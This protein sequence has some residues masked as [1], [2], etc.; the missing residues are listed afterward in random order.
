MTED[1]LLCCLE[2]F[3]ST[4][5]ELGMGLGL[6]LVRD[7]VRRHH[8]VLEVESAPGQGA[9]FTIRLP[10]PPHSQPAATASPSS[11]AWLLTPVAQRRGVPGL[12]GGHWDVEALQKHPAG[13]VP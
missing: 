3:F 5:G 2:P 6:T 1:V 12:T 8:G 10:L 7:M 4:K 11:D 9:T 13:P